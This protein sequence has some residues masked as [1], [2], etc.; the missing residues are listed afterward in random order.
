M[1]ILDIIAED[2]SLNEGALSKWFTRHFTDFME[3]RA[4]AKLIAEIEKK[5]ANDLAKQTAC[6]ELSEK[7]G[8]YLAEREL[9][10][11]S[12]IPL[13]R[14]ILKQKEYAGT[15]FAK[16]PEF[17]DLTTRLAQ[18]KKTQYLKDGAQAGKAADDGVEAGKSTGAKA[19]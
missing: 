7:Y 19:G 8:K 9:A 12:P 11:Q 3:R 2:K 6:K 10:G 5:Y 18:V 4:A 16:D 14:L 17:I 15:S 13:E 1:K